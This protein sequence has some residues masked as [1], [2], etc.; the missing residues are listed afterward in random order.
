[1]TKKFGDSMKAI[2]EKS[3]KHTHFFKAPEKYLKENCIIAI[4]NIKNILEN[5]PKKM[6]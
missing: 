5:L 3:Q 2:L 4:V 1:M 6:F